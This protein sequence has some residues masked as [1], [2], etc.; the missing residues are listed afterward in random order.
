MGEGQYSR[1]VQIQNKMPV[2]F[3]SRRRK[4]RGRRRHDN[5][6]SKLVSIE[7]LKF[8]TRERT[9]DG[10]KRVERAEQC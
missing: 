4:L 5:A 2:V 1:I 9:T 8:P 10:F 6:R 7:F 3:S